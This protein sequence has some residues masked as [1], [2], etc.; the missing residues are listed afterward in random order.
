MSDQ[1]KSISEK[2][3]VSFD[4][5]QKVIEIEKNHVYK[6]K[7]FISGDLKSIIEETCGSDKK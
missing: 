4:I 1:L 5:I 7:R 2:N 3:G 6:K